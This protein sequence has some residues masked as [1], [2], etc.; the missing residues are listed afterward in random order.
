MS[1]R[2]NKINIA[3]IGLGYVGLP[4]ALS[5][6]KKFN[7]FGYDKNFERINELRSNYDRNNEISNIQLSNTT[8]KISNNIY[9]IATANYF[10]IT[11][12]TPVHK[13]KTPN[14]IPIKNATL[15]VSKFIKKND[16]VIYESTLFPGATDDILIPIIEKNS[17]LKINEDF[18]CGYSP[19]RINPGDK[20]HSLENIKKI[21]S[22]SN[23]NTL[24][25]INN[26]YSKIIKA[27]THPVSSIKIAESAKVIENIQ[28]DLNI[29]LMNELSIIFNKLNINTDEIIKAAGTKWN[30]A[31]YK[32]GL[33]GGHCIGVDSYYLTYKSKLIGYN[34]ELILSARKLNDSMYLYVKNTFLKMIK[35]RINNYNE[36][37]IKILIMGLSFKENVNDCRNS[38]SLLL[39][40]NFIKNN[41]DITVFEKL[42]TED[43]KKIFRKRD[44]IKF[45]NNLKNNFYDGIIITVPHLYIKKIGVKKIKKSLKKNGV[46]YDVKSLFP[47]E[48]SELQL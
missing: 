48:N 19:E 9:S 43:Q 33:V 13:N 37:K 12:P 29:G 44:K 39:V 31:K 10:I 45:K 18:Y 7:V 21:V 47:K 23:K 30:F 22:G 25:K 14:L 20:S 42:I 16:I 8:L 15:S 24:N 6:S 4:L 1:L 41:F 28:R 3:I 11:V 38:Q 27:G 5:F 26:L 34:P 35:T 46:L 17:S 2:S 36:S 32:P 40:K